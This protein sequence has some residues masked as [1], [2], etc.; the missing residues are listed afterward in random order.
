MT[1]TIGNINILPWVSDY[2][3]D[4]IP[5]YG[6][7]K[8]ICENGDEVDDYKGDKVTVSF[9]LR[10]VPIDMAE[11]ISAVL[12]GSPFS[13]TVPAPVDIS[14]KFMK[15]SYH[16][17]PYDKITKWHFDVTIESSGLINSGDSL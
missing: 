8:F 3:I 4:L 16:A 9:S 15:T 7:N 11:K 10:R 6:N 13:C 14:M 1:F 2:K 5:Q 12:E 17:E